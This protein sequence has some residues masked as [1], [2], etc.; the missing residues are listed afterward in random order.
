V[1][2]ERKPVGFAEL[3]EAAERRYEVLFSKTRQDGLQ[4]RT[5]ER[6]VRR[7]QVAEL[8]ANAEW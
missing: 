4:R 3:Y 2:H 5:R 6:R 1:C 7:L 8:K